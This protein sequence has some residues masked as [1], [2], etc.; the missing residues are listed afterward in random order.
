MRV[1]GTRHRVAP[2]SSWRSWE[3]HASTTDTRIRQ[4]LLQETRRCRVRLAEAQV[5]G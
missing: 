1:E 3:P 2:A 4:R 5:D